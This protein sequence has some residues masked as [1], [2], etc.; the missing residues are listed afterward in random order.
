MTDNVAAL[1]FANNSVVDFTIADDSYS[2]L[3]N[4]QP[5][6]LNA[7]ALTGNVTSSAGFALAG[8]P[9]GQLNILA[10]DSV[11]FQGGPIVMV[12]VPLANYSPYYAPRY[13]VLSNTADGGLIT[14]N[15][16][17]SYVG[18]HIEGGLHAG[19]TQPDQIVAL[20]GDIVGQDTEVSALNLPKETTIY[21]GQNIQDLGFIIQNNAATDI[22]TETA[23]NNIIDTTVPTVTLNAVQ[24]V[25]NGPGRI[26][27]SAG[28]TF[29]LGDGSGVVTEGNLQNP[30][31]PAGGAAINIQAGTGPA[32]YVAFADT[33]VTA[34]NLPAADQTALQSYVATINPT[35]ASSVDA[36]WSAFKALPAA[37]QT[38][39]L[40]S[41]KPDLNAIFFTQLVAASKISGLSLFDSTIA[42]LYPNISSAVNPNGGDIN[43]FG[44]TLTTQ[45]GGSIYLFAPD[46]SVYAGLNTMPSYFNANNKPASS[47]GVFSIGGGAIGALVHDNFEVD[48]GRVFTLAGGDISLVSQYGDLSAGAG[49]KTASSAPP[50]ILTT[51]QLGVTVLDISG[52]I[53]GSGIATLKTNPDVPDANIYVIAPRG[54]FDAGDAGVRSSGSVD[55]N[56]LVVLNG[57]NIV[58]AGAISGVPTVESSNISAAVPSNATPNSSDIAKNIANAATNGD[59]STTTLSV[60]VVGYG[61]ECKDGKDGCGDDKTKGGKGQAGTSD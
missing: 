21:A 61:A 5:P 50:P 57:G 56:A 17:E 32:N 6:N 29:D 28:N 20:N 26:D 16:S 55:V 25:V 27:I 49:T 53:S 31:L 23:G 40:D 60:D 39:F 9:K 14:G 43:I 12:D 22:T 48:Q 35:A 42:S 10:G 3:Y 52:S 24:H 7:I 41:I 13:L 34:S 47:L 58:A 44:S 54:V 46:G 19:D 1:A 33:Y 38:A 2:T 51:N 36:A 18:S 37:Q 11:Q 30:Y 45:Q 59:G 15:V 4:Y 8:A